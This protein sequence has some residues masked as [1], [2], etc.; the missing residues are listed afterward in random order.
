MIFYDNIYLKSFTSQKWKID[1]SL[2]SQRKEEEQ[3]DNIEV[4]TI[5]WNKWKKDF[6]VKFIS[7]ASTIFLGK[8]YR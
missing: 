4:T 8:Y 6:N 2:P 7:V 5:I 1:R 3:Y